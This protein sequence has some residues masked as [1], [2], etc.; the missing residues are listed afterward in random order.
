[1]LA[2]GRGKLAFRVM[3]GC[4]VLLAACAGSQHGSGGTTGGDG[5]DAGPP[6][7]EELTG[8]LSRQTLSELLGRSVGDFLRHVEVENVREEGSFVGWRI[9]RLPETK[10]AWLD[11]NV[12]DVVTAI[13]GMPLERPDDA[14][15]VWEILQ[16]AS[17]VRIDLTRDG[18][19]RS[20]RIPIEEGGEPPPAEDG[21][22][23][24]PAGDE[25]PAPRPGPQE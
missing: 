1:M 12:G 5:A 11:V 13:N 10:P 17:E 24:A 15:R 16:V 8:E 22:E 25:A 23:P 2:E 7:V 14:Q 6:P 19:R 9:E 21:T 3:L 4:V 18:E 20:V